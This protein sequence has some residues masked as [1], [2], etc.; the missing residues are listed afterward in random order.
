MSDDVHRRTAERT[1]TTLVVCATLALAGMLAS[2]G[3]R[4]DDGGA[5]P[6]AVTDGTEEDARTP[7]T[8]ELAEELV[9]M[10]IAD[11]EVRRGLGPETIQDTAL[12][13]RMLRTDSAHASRLRELVERRGW[14]RRSEV[15]QE[16][17][18]AAFLVVQHA[19]FDD[20]QAAMLPHVE[21]AVRAGEL[22]VQ[23]YA[24][25]FDRVQV[26]RG[27]P[28][29]Y[30]TQLDGPV[31]G[32]LRLHPLEDS[33]AVDSLRAELGL[34]SLDEYLAVIEE[35]YGMPVARRDMAP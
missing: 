2:C 27:L 30:G 16:A 8:P 5:D 3:G 13:G 21:E 1:R 12:L 22:E 26:D 28:Q 34:P 29:R 23:D 25:L 32:E 35:A 18:E 10:G 14:P 24:L 31:D 19:P 17:V 15:G 6:E 33:S 9:A 11:Q 7:W 4:A 20:W